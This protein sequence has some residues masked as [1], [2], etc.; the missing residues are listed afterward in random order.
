MSFSTEGSSLPLNRYCSP[1]YGSARFSWVLGRFITILGEGTFRV[2][3]KT[4]RSVAASRY[5]I[6]KKFNAIEKE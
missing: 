1:C 5:N 2:S 3:L 4:S 6:E